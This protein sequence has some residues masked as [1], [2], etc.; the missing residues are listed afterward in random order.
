MYV[1][2]KQSKFHL[3]SL[4][5]AEVETKFQAERVNTNDDL[6]HSTIYLIPISPYIF[7]FPFIDRLMD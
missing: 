5:I 4:Q 7:I 2:E 6:F 3:L 1:L